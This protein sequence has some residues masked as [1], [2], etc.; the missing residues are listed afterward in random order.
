MKTFRT[1]AL[2][3]AISITAI[4][5]SEDSARIEE[6]EAKYVGKPVPFSQFSEIGDPETLSGT[7]GKRWVVY[8]DKGDFTFVTEKSTN[9]VMAVYDGRH[10]L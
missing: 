6:L 10:E 1:L 4:C 3:L 7:D 9:T 5:C 8:F 2:V